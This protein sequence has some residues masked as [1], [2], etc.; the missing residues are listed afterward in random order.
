MN[1]K[2]NKLWHGSAGPMLIAEI[3]GNA[4]LIRTAALYH[5]IGKMKNPLYFIENQT[6]G[7]NP[8]DELSFEESAEI[9]I[10]HV[11]DGVKLAKKNKLPDRIIDFIR[12]HHGTTMVQ[13]FYKQ[14]LKNFPDEV[15][16]KSKFSYKGPRPFSRETAVLMM[17]DAVEAASRSL[18]EPNAENI[19]GLVEGIINHQMSE[20][21][22]ENV[23][24]TMKDLSDIKKIFKKK[25]RSIYHVR[26][27]YPE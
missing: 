10:A 15:V 18:K 20:R 7:F 21:Q 9:I 4:L 6:S 27:E 22:F 19:D 24:I 12:T 5:D 13:Y 14:Y 11:S 3:G 2:N 16:D 23:D 26:V 8:H 1:K 17:S 25:L